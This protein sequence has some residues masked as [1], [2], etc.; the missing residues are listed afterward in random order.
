MIFSHRLLDKYKRSKLQYMT[1]VYENRYL[2]RHELPQLSFNLGY[3]S[4]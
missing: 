4:F 2:A 1:Y 3:I